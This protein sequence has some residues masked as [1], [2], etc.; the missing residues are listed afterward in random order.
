MSYQIDARR[1]AGVVTEAN[2]ALAG[3]NFNHG[4]L[5]VGL[6]ELIGRVIVDVAS[7]SIQADEMMDVVK[8]HLKRTVMY[9]SLAQEKQLIIPG[10]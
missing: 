7:T 2:L 6:S 3:K 1:V 5:I 9:G 8:D 4:E 10:G